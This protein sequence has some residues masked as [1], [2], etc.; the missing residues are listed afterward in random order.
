MFC[1]KWAQTQPL[2][3]SLTASFL[4][5]VHSISTLSHHLLLPSFPRW[6]F[7]LV[8]DISGLST[9][10]S[11]LQGNLTI[12]TKFSTSWHSRYPEPTEPTSARSVKKFLIMFPESLEKS[13]HKSTIHEKVIMNLFCVSLWCQMHLLQNFTLSSASGTQG[14]FLFYDMFIITHSH[15]PTVCK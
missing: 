7:L 3:N 12:V 6:I 5:S 11:G 2:A 13:Y 10:L 15:L 1:K 9:F 14:L 4:T 8:K